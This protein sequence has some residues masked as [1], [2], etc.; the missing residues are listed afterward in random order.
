MSELTIC[1][2]SHN[3]KPYTQACIQAII[4]NTKSPYKLYVADD[5]TDGTYEWLEKQGN[6]DKIFYSPAPYSGA[7]QARN[8]FL[9]ACATKYAVAMDNDNL[10]PMGWETHIPEWWDSVE[11]SYPKG[12]GQK[13]GGMIIPAV[14][15]MYFFKPLEFL[16]SYVTIC[17][18]LKKDIGTDTPE[19]LHQIVN[20]T[21]DGDFDKFAARFRVKGRHMPA[22]P[23]QNTWS[24]YY[25]KP[26]VMKDV[27]GY[28]EHYYGA[29]WEDLDLARRM[30]MMGYGTFV[31]CWTLVHHFMG[32][33][34]HSQPMSRI[35]E[36]NN[37]E[38]YQCKFA[39]INLDPKEK[40]LG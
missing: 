39:N 30:N 31:L 34:R 29:G 3:T 21:Y 38:R 6:I 16:K 33:T 25:F 8:Q 11:H 28:D 40:Y 15:D 19:K 27:G 1:V 24:F 9:K 4:K 7:S 22:I 14:L 12:L 10:V 26:K 17:K 18:Q 32:T 35:H 20:K 13:D 36:V 5:S 2:N 23:F 37:K